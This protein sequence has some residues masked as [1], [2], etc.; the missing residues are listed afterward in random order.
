MKKKALLT[1]LIIL[2]LVTASLQ[3]Y[4]TRAQTTP[5]IRIVNPL[6]GGSDFLF[7]TSDPLGT[8]FNATAEVNNTENLFAYQV[9]VTIN[10]TLLNI[11]RAW[12]P[13]WDASWVFA[14][15][16]SVRPTP[17][18][19][20]F[21]TDGSFESAKVG[22]SMLMGDPFTGSGLLAIVEF[23]IIHIPA[24]GTVSCDMTID[25]TDTYLLNYDLDEVPVTKTGG[26]YEYVGPAGPEPPHAEFTYTPD[27]PYIGTPITFDASSSTPNGGELTSYTW[28]FG[29]GSPPVTESD[30]VT[31][32]S[33]ATNE[34]FDV[35]LTVL[36]TEG[37]SDMTMQSIEVLTEPEMDVDLNDDRQ[38]DITDIA[39]VALAFGSFPG[40]E[41]WNESADVNKDEMVCMK[42]I[43]LVAMNFGAIL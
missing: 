3:I 19:Y 2:A 42:D 37:L 1:T 6:T 13:H 41:N 24:Q 18:F 32:H 8:R 33:Y 17:A 28:D 40:H 36:D 14:G 26:Y 16:S 39:I 4:M 5:E 12:L 22:D 43:V 21:D 10:D 34:T 25:S 11:T 7:T 9:Y 38:V 31:T 27:T 35:M 30:P 20:D 15:K 29:D 23:E